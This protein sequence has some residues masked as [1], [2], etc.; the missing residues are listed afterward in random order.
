MSELSRLEIW[1]RRADRRLLLM[2]YVA[3]AGSTALVLGA[4]DIDVPRQGLPVTLAV[5]AVTAGWL[6]WMVTWHPQWA[7]RDGI[8]A[9]FF[10]GLLVLIALLV[11]CHPFY[12]FFAWTGYLLTM[13]ALRG[14]WRLAG[15][16]AVACCTAAS[17]VGGFG[18]LRVPGNW[19]SYLLML[20]LNVGVAVAMTYLAGTATEHAARRAKLV[21]ELSEA[22]DK[23]AAALREN[24]G[25]QAQL[26]VQAREA[27]VLDERQR[28]AG[29]IHDVLAQGLTGI[30]M[31]L[32]AA[33]QAGGRAGE[34]QRHLD[35]AKQLAR[36][37]LAEARR[38][39]RALRPQPLVG[40]PLPAALAEVADAWSA[41][42]GVAAE[43]IVT[44]AAQALLPEIEAALLRT[45]Q[46]A[47]SNVARHADAGRVALTL[48]YL[49]DVVT[50]DVRDDG[51]G[52]D[53]ARR[54]PESDEGGYGLTAMRER[55]QR[56]AGTLAVESEPGSGTAVSACVPALPVA[57]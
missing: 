20:A 33:E 40:T 5:V 9:T 44:G 52:F 31:Q 18:V 51:A 47:L 28:L 11:W 49:G 6:L 48:S 43:V 2:P 21:R 56:I 16:A 4:G 23:L 19:P 36:D 8:M 7:H 55:V 24:A 14:H 39:V 30:V 12:G 50:L 37:S 57:A 42:H 1:R 15:A 38:S 27:G 41:R 46:E 10:I 53:P 29:E 3:L 34:R 25:L 13:Y 32:E 45:A 22:N 17:Q 54:R 26:L 35:T